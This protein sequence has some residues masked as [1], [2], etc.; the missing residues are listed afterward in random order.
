[1]KI[2]HR[3]KSVENK[4]SI[5]LKKE[6]LNSPYYFFPQRNYEPKKKLGNTAFKT[7]SKIY[8]QVLKMNY[9]ELNVTTSV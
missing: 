9:L 1:M 7:I 2:I 6:T 8:H 5:L 3:H 4:N